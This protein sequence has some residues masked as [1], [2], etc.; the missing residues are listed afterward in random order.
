[1]FGSIL[2]SLRGQPKPPAIDQLQAALVKAVAA[3]VSDLHDGEWEDRDWLRIG[4]NLELLIDGGQRISNQA[5]VIAQKPGGSLEKLSFRLRLANKEKFVEL[6]QAMGKGNK[7]RWTICDLQIE[8]DGRFAFS[9]GYGP[10]PRL[11]GDLLHTPLSDMLER[12]RAETGA[13]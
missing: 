9:F 8:R 12:Y 3:D 11:G 4:V 7:E 13:T 5:I 10:P 6:A 1:M 2:R